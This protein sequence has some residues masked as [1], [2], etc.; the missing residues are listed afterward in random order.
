MEDV[1]ILNIYSLIGDLETLRPL[2]FKLIIPN[3]DSVKNT[4][5]NIA[6]VEKKLQVENLFVSLD[7]KGVP[8]LFNDLEP[9]T[10]NVK[11][12][13]MKKS[14]KVHKSKEMVGKQD[15]AAIVEVNGNLKPQD[16][17]KPEVG[18]SENDALTDGNNTD[19][20]VPPSQEKDDEDTRNEAEIASEAPVEVLEAPV[21]LDYNG[22][23]AA[24]ADSKPQDELEKLFSLLPG[25]EL[26]VDAEGLLSNSSLVMLE[27]LVDSLEPATF[28]C[29]LGLLERS[30]L[31]VASQSSCG[32]KLVLAVLKRG[33]RAEKL[34]LLEVLYQ[35]EMLGRLLSSLSGFQAMVWSLALCS[36]EEATALLSP[37]SV[38]INSLGQANFAPY[39]LAAFVKKFPRASVGLLDE[40]LGQF[41][42]LKQSPNVMDFFMSLAT[43]EIG[44]TKVIGWVSQR[45][46]DVLTDADKVDY[47]IKVIGR[48]EPQHSE[49]LE[50]LWRKLLDQRMF[51][52]VASSPVGCPL[53][54]EMVAAVI[55]GRCGG[56][57][58]RSEVIS[59]LAQHVDAL[60]ATPEGIKI[61]K[62]L[63]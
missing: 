20:V 48:L 50:T 1:D 52:S 41:D 39:F 11:P 29:L 45:F 46:S 5:K 61:L 32:A 40:I 60:C 19:Q 62:F 17:V 57:G 35:E 38:I 21:V 26:E 18:E 16:S 34:G 51:L 22:N 58:L 55:S 54:A 63:Q 10:F 27:G 9:I 15:Q 14:T 53:L 7:E 33:S 28:Q 25:L 3:M 47:L 2:C 12:K 59:V 36:E 8:T 4:A 6:R 23:A 42:V 56:E 13:P 31:E 30:L 24:G 37:S 43:T 49:L 44:L